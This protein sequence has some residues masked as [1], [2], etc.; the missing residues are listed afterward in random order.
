MRKYLTKFTL[1]HPNFGI[2]GL[3]RYIAIANAV[4]WV[5]GMIKP[6]FTSY[7]MFNIPSILSG[8]IWRII[9]FIFI[10]P[11]TSILGI[12][13][14][15]FY[16]IIGTTLEQC[17]GTP[18][19]SLFILSGY[20]MTLLFGV[21]VFLLG[22]VNVWLSASYIFLSMFFAFA[23]LFPDQQVL[24]MFVIPIKMKYLALV[25]LAFFILEIFLNKFPMNLLPVIAILNVLLF[26]FDEIKYAFKRR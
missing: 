1:K 17:W 3:M 18:R 22:Y 25:D 10:P 9:S 15:Y 11:S 16:Y 2:P 12:I 13:G 20:L 14:I 7:L 26:C 8:Q 24:Y 23:L 4:F 19:F 21:I 5:L 6:S